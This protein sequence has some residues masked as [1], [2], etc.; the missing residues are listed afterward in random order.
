MK[1]FLTIA[2]ILVSSLVLITVNAN[3][4][5][6]ELRK[7]KREQQQQITKE[8]M[9]AAIAQQMFYFYPRTYAMPYSNP[10]NIDSQGEYYL[11]FYPSD[12]IINLPME[13]G[14]QSQYV[15]Y[16]SGAQYSDYT[17]KDNGD[18]VNY[19][20]TAQLRNVS[21]SNMGGA[22]FDLNDQN[23]NLGI[24]LSIN[25]LYGNAYLTITP[26]FA[27]PTTYQGTIITSGL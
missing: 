10:V 26:D 19:T 4:D 7:Q 1:K 6:A 21:N 12:V 3:N 14:Q 5:K 16:N 17:V 11:D 20:I 15:F 9:K 27:A 24:H 2:I 25:I 8:K 18:G 23:V 13:L 22:A